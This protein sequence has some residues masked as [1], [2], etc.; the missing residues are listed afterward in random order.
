MTFEQQIVLWQPFFTTVATVAA[1]LVGLLFVSLSINRDKIT[2]GSNRLLLRIAQRSFSDFIIV[3]LV[4]L[5]FLIPG[6][7]RRALAF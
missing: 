7:G 2:A 4:A 6:E 1:T 5:F 3:L